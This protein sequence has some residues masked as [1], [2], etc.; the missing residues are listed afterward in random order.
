MVILKLILLI[1]LFCKQVWAGEIF[2]IPYFPERDLTHKSVE[3][4]EKDI[5]IFA[6]ITPRP[7]KSLQYHTIHLKFMK[8]NNYIDINDLTI[9]LNMKMDMGNLIYKPAVVNGFTTATFVLPK[10]VL[11]DKRWYIKIEFSYKGSKYKSIL[12]FD[13]QN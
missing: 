10:C 12:F 9:K 13:T 2:T 8:N 3:I 11:L 7:I 1:A 4:V 6:N 5:K